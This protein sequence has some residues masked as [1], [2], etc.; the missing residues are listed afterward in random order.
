VE[1]KEVLFGVSLRKEKKFGV[2]QKEKEKNL[3]F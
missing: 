3:V 1:R 2:K